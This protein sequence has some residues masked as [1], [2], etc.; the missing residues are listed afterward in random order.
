VAS[1][2][3]VFDIETGNPISQAPARRFE[4]AQALMAL[5]EKAVDKQEPWAAFSQQGGLWDE[6]NLRRL[7]AE[8]PAQATQHLSL[9]DTTIKD[10]AAFYATTGAEVLIVTAD[11][12]LKP[13]EPPRPPPLPRRRR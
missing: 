4:T 10:V 13:F 2:V 5:L 7:V 8:W 11:A 6:T 9:G 12:G 3:L 1:R